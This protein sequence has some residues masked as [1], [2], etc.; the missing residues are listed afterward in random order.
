MI[1][2]EIKRNRLT[3]TAELKEEEFDFWDELSHHRGLIEKKCRGCS[4]VSLAQGQNENRKRG[5]SR[6][7]WSVGGSRE[8]C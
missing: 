2:N 7:T 4:A 5:S 1:A 6:H 3:E 8:C